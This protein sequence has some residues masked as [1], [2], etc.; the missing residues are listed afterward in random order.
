MNNDQIKEEIEKLL[1]STQR[2][3]MENLIAYMNESGFFK[4]P[5]STK[6][7]GCYEGGLAAHSLNVYNA[8]EEILATCE[9]VIPSDSLIIA[10]LLHDLCKV[11]AYIGT[12]KPYTYNTKQPPGH[13][14]LSLSRVKAYIFLSELETAM[15]EFHMGV[16][17]SREFKHNGEYG[18]KRMTDIWAIYPATKL[19]YFADEL[20]TLV[21]KAGEK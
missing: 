12:A 14:A 4:S 17:G 9:E 19:M 7:H 20:A 3:G 21:E 18:L 5:G 2:E 10:T 1:R 13:A 15:I 8:L 16:Y 11:G 6:F